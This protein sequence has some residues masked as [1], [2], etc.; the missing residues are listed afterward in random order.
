MHE[1][2]SPSLSRRKLLG[3]GI[4]ALA[5]ITGSGGIW[6]ISSR[7]GAAPA[8]LVIPTRV[9]TAGTSLFTYTGHTAP[10]F[11]VAWSPDGRRIASASYDNTAQVWDATKGE[12]P[13]ITYQGLTGLV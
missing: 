4:G 9:P 2:P 11:S 7:H 3:L 6:Y 13:L 8:P 1:K 10:V 5:V 12:N